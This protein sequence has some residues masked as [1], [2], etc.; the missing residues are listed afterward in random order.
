MKY[1]KTEDPEI[2]RLILH[3][4]KRQ[5]NTLM[6][7]PS[8]NMVSC[9]VEEAVGSCLGNKYA[10]GYPFR[11]YYQ[12]QSV[13]DKI[14]TLVIERAKKLFHVPYV[15]V[16]PLSG[17]PANLAVYTALCERNDTIM[18]LSLAF[19]GHLTHG[20]AVSITGKFFKSIQYGLTKYGI[21]DYDQVE[22]LALKERPK[23]I[24]AGTTAYSKIID[25]ERFAIIAK[26]VNAYL[27]A[28]ISHIAGLIIAHLFLL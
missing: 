18:G 26:K 11:R 27:L 9:A 14:E 23:I 4:Q 16:Q 13:I 15:N 24:V 10:E 7:I 28:D 3:E 5:E 17:S 19:G 12:G 22:K 6:M 20:A 25:W 8:E 2:A 1:L 21:I